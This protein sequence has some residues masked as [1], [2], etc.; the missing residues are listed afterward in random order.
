MKFKLLVLFCITGYCSPVFS[1][2]KPI[3]F[4]TAAAFS[5]YSYNEFAKALDVEHLNYNLQLNMGLKLFQK[6]STYFNMNIDD[7]TMK[8]FINIA[9]AF[10]SKYIGVQFDYHKVSGKL[11]WDEYWRDN[12]N[13]PQ[14]KD[15]E[16]N[17]HWSTVALIFP[18]IASK[19]GNI[20]DY[21]GGDI[22]FGLFWNRSILPLSIDRNESNV[23]DALSSTLDPEFVSNTWGLRISVA[24]DMLTEHRTVS[25]IFNL[26][27]LPFDFFYYL[28]AVFD[29]GLGIGKPSEGAI[30]RA[31]EKGWDYQGDNLKMFYTRVRDMIGIGKEWELNNAQI[32]FVIGIDYSLERF[33]DFS[34]HS[35]FDTRSMGPFV[36]FGVL[37]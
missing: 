9:G 25:E 21:L 2:D 16:F 35:S 13:A 23:L 6:M 18:R 3:I 34:G 29:I 28:N 11:S 26:P 1:L 31:K 4:D 27:N 20:G 22:L 24:Q 17:Q 36:R 14:K 30:S 8:R 7:P 15:T 5:W 32:N 12:I 19:P 33:Q 10:G 37:F